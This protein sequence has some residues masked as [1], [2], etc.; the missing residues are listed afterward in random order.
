MPEWLSDPPASRYW[1]LA[2]LVLL[3]TLISVQKR[4]RLWYLLAGVIALL[5]LLT[6]LADYFWQSP[7]EEAVQRM[8]AIIQ[9][10]Q[11][12]QPDACIL[13]VA[14]TITYQGEH[15]QALKITRE[16]LRQAAFWQLLKQFDVRVHAWDFAREDVTRP[17]PQ[18][19]EIGFLA[20][21]EA[22]GKRV[23]FYIRAAFTRQ[24]DGT[25][26]LTQLQSFDPLK[27]QKERRSIPGFPP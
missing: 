1:L 19:V 20:Q 21:G 12:H 17:D 8:Q 6:F 2:A 7:R 15:A 24:P 18:T 11:R 9:A 22:E 27:R 10:V 25:W 4:Q 26:K 5:L 3:L 13:H 14:D 16:Q 23:P